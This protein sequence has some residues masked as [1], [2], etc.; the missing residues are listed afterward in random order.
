[1]IIPW[2]SLIISVIGVFI[3]VII[4]MNYA[5]KKIKKEN[6]LEALREENI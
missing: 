1:M 5:S 2:D 6:I 4:A 3:I